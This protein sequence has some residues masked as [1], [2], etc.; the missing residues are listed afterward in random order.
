[1][2]RDLLHRL[3]R[4]CRGLA[5][6]WYALVLMTVWSLSACQGSASGLEA[7]FP[8]AEGRSWTY[9]VRSEPEGE[10]DKP[11]QTRLTLSNLGLHQ[12]DGLEGGPA[13]KRRSSEGMD[14]FLRQDI[15][16][17]YRVGSR[18]ELRDTITLD[19]I[20]RTVL[21]WPLQVG[22]TWQASTTTY[23][24]KR[25]AEFPRE[26]R[27]SHPEIPM[28]Y[29]VEAL[30]ASVQTPAGPFSGCAQVRGEA[31]LRLFVD[32][33]QGWRDVPLVT[34]EWYCP[35]VGLVKLTREER[36]ASGF[37]TGGLITLELNEWH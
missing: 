7:W 15:A 22:S 20:P 14:Y 25:R 37:L 35:G 26:V 17:T 5:W 8:L 34:N 19:P 10:I 21:K 2:S 30:D 23:L 29:T 36:A 28:T 18:S 4:A 6:A 32:P 24:L 27:H 13:F 33:V 1:M 31:K 16:G 12:V 3:W 11:S 9:T